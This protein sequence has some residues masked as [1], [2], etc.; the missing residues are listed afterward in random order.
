MRLY[1]HNKSPEPKRNGA[2][3]RY[4]VLGIVFVSAVLVA[5]LLLIPG[6]QPAPPLPFDTKGFVASNFAPLFPKPANPSLKERLFFGWIELMRL[7]KA[8]SWSFPATT[9]RCS[10]HGLLNE[11]MEVSGNRYLLSPE[12]ASGSVQL[13]A[14]N[15]LD[16]PHW[17]AEVERTLHTGKVE[18]WDRELKG[19]RKEPLVFIRFPAQK[20][21]LVLPELQAVE[22]LRTNATGTVDGKIH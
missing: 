10:I 8:D 16:G 14:T 6:K 3:L 7:F 21:V 20:T 2:S 22:F 18:W 11:C 4:Y 17:V 13:S 19:W 12:I 15:T 1:R 5:M 9:A